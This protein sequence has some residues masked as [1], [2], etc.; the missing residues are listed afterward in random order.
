MSNARDNSFIPLS[1]AAP[2]KANGDS[3]VTIISQTEKAQPFRPLG[4]SA[5]A[6]S[7]EHQTNCEPRVTMERDGERITSIKV[8]CSCGQLI[9][10]ACVY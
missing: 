2:V 7:A 5:P 10:L 6:A 8:Q 1:T 3:K 4:Q 9:E